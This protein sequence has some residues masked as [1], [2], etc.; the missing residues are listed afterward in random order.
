MVVIGVVAYI[1]PH[2]LHSYCA[3]LSPLNDSVIK[4]IFSCIN[5]SKRQVDK[6]ATRPNN[7][8]E[9]SNVRTASL[10]VRIQQR[11]HV[12]PVGSDRA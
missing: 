11:D 3:A 8:S 10:P 7:P 4:K 6:V 9:R 1:I 5:I 12:W 2:G